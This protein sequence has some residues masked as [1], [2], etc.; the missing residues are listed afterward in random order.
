MIDEYNNHTE[1]RFVVSPQPQTRRGNPVETL[2]ATSLQPQ[3]QSRCVNR[4]HG[5]SNK[6]KNYS[7]IKNDKL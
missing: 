1:T 6:L 2:H 4:N 7:Q 5:D 3:P